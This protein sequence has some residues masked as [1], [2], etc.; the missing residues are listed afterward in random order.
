GAKAE[1]KTSPSA[2]KEKEAPPAAWMQFLP[3]AAIGLFFYFILLRPQQAEQRRR[4]ELLAALKKNDRVVTTGGMIGTIADISSDGL[5]VT[6]KLDDNT[7][8]KFLRSAIQEPLKDGPE[9]NG[10]GST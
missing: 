10:S 8:I 3:F 2:A 5:R 6:L 7:R 1:E 9:S 4:K